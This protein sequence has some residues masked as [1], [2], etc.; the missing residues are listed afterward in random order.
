MIKM[1]EKNQ[2]AVEH[3]LDKVMLRVSSTLEELKSAC[4]E[5]Q[6]VSGSVNSEI[7]HDAI[8]KTQALDRVTQTLDCL[9]EFSAALALLPNIE[10]ITVGE[11]EFSSISL[12]SVR[13]VIEMADGPK[14]DP[15]FEDVTLF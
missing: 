13:E 2:T 15:Q 12:P 6:S 8:R 14:N 11:K 10:N 9:S 3:Q 4:A 5:V 1:I 7:D